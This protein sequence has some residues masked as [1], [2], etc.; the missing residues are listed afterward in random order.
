MTL[1]KSFVRHLSAILKQVWV[2]GIEYDVLLNVGVMPWLIVIILVFPDHFD[3]VVVY[4]V[5]LGLSNVLCEWDRL[6]LIELNILQIVF[7][8]FKRAIFALKL[9]VPVRI[10]LIIH[11]F[12][13]LFLHMQVLHLFL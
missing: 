5:V 7:T 10:L 13:V 6:V 11:Q 4:L 8:H 1:L 3:V 12:G 9:L 2:H